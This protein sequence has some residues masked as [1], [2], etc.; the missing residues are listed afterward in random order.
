[1]NEDHISAERRTLLKAGG[2]LAAAAAV[3]A[4]L[5]GFN[6]RAATGALQGKMVMVTGASRGIGEAIAR[7]FAAEGATVACLAR[8][9][10]PGTGENKG[11][12]K[13]TVD[14]IAKAGGKAYAV[15]CD[16]ADRES[17]KAA[18][19]EVL[20]KLG[21]VDILVNNA[22]AANLGTHFDELTLKQYTTTMELNLN[23]PFDFI[24][25]L[26]PA[27]RTRG[28][29]WIL[30]ISSSGA[31]LSKGPPFNPLERN[32]LMTYG[33]TKAA[34]NRMTVG[35]A[36]ELQDTGVAVNALA[37]TSAVWTPGFVSSGVAKMSGRSGPGDQDEPVESMAEAAL[38]LCT[39]DGKVFTGKCLYS[40][41]YLKEINRT[42]MT[43][44]GKKPWKA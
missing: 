28:Q 44:D 4:V 11:S 8:T 38:S 25:Q 9:L 34:L 31:E 35:M 21:R 16:V 22:A 20:A 33:I 18:V 42:V 32:G 14:E 5:P 24:Q 3:D 2:V 43:L 29:G 37:P 19:T 1:M 10:E 12:L 39:V 26:A 7:R 23:G 6:A 40:T 41:K 27:M 17:R 15:K 30:N 36:A 13:E